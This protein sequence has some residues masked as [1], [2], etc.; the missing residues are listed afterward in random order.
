MFDQVDGLVLGQARAEERGALALGEPGLAG[1]AVEESMLLGL[2]VVASD[3]EI[4]VCPLAVVGAIRVLATETGQVVHG[5][6]S[7]IA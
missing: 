2:A 6:A 4:A 5:C 1:A 3:S 7:T